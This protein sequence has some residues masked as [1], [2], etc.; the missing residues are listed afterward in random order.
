MSPRLPRECSKKQEEQI[1]VD[2]TGRR[3]PG[4]ETL[5]KKR[6]AVPLVKMVGA[7]APH[8]K[9]SHLKGRAVGGAAQVSDRPAQYFSFR[10]KRQ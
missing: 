7:A 6:K 2:S 3:E 5:K 10:G 9:I 8:R 4:H 1:G